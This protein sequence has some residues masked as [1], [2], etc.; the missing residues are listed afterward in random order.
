MFKVGERVFDINYGWGKVTTVDGFVVVKFE[1][2]TGKYEYSVSGIRIFHTTNRTL[3]HHDYTPKDG[4][5]KGELLEVSDNVL[6]KRE[7]FAGMAMHGLVSKKADPTPYSVALDAVKFADALI[8]T[9]NER[10]TQ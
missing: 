8:R 6:T 1:E 4:E 9:L 10:K 2:Y 5:I 3:Y 7:K